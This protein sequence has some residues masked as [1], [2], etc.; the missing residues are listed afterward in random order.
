[1]TI[2]MRKHRLTALCG[3]ALAPLI[4]GVVS[5]CNSSTKNMDFSDTSEAP[6][7]KSHAPPGF[8]N[9]YSVKASSRQGGNP[10]AKPSPPK[11][12]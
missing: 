11:K 3:F 2:S 8:H 7:V 12:P 5:G 1:M 9:N 10:D 6:K 4:I